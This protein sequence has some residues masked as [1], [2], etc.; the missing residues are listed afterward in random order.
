[1]VTSWLLHLRSVLDISDGQKKAGEQECI[2]N[3]LI[4]F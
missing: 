1:M 2:R 3:V 4:N